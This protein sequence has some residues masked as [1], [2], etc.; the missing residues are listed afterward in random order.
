VAKTRKRQN[1]TKRADSESSSRISEGTLWAIPVPGLGF[2]PIVVARASASDA[3]VDFAFVYLK[4]TLLEQQPQPD[5][6]PPLAEWDSAWIGLVSNRPFRTGRWVRC[7]D[8]CGFDRRAWPV[9]PSRRSDVDETKPETEWDKDPWG[10]FWSIETT[11]DEPTMTVIDN[12]PASRQEALR[13][14]ATTVV[15]GAS[16]LEKSLVNH[17]KRR[18]AG[19]WDMDLSPQAVTPDSIKVWLDYADRVRS[20]HSNIRHDWLPAGRKTDKSLQPG[21]WLGFPLLG[22]GFGAAILIDRPDPHF[23]LF[24]DTVVMA[25]RR[26]WDRWPTLDDVRALCP[27]DGVFIAQTSFICV[28]DGRWRV[29]GQHPNFDQSEWPWPIPWFQSPVEKRRSVVSVSTGD[30]EPIQVRIEPATLAQD[31]HAGQRCR[32]SSNYGH[33]ESAVPRILAGTEPGLAD[34]DGYHIGIVTPDRLAAWRAINAA[35]LREVP[36]QRR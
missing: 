15:I 30:G 1:T 31:P 18:K 29:L 33:F 22:G 21:G 19:F 32:G 25:M 9:P 10:E 11:A 36:A 8:I 34:T 13:F 23:R 5:S 28:R 3:E 7:G 17:F 24:S 12:A 20:K 27:E 35:I 16:R 14:P 6:I 2:C 26:R 4:P